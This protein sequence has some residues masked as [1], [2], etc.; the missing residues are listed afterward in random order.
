VKGL[1]FFLTPI[2]QTLVLATVLI[3]N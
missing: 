1:Q 2:F 3:R